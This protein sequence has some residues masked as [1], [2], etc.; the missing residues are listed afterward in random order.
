MI[1][2]WKKILKDYTKRDT[3]LKSSALD[4]FKYIGPGLLVTVGF[5]DPGNWASNFAAGS[6]FGYTLLWV[7]SL[8]TIMLILLQHNVAHLGIV[9]GLCLSEAANKYLPRTGSR[10]VLWSAIAASVSTSLAEILGGAIALNMLFGIPIKVAAVLV[11][12]F[13]FC[14]MFSSSYKKIEKYIIAFVSIIGLSFIYEL[15]LVDIEWGEAARSW[16]VPSVPQGSILIIMS[17][18]GAVVMPHNLFLH[19]EIIQS[20]EWN[21]KDD[22]VIEKQLKYEFFDTLFSMVIGWAINSA[23]ILLAAA[24]FHKQGIVVDDLQQAKSLLEPLLG[25]AAAI[26]FGI[27]LLFAGISSSM[28]SGIAAGSIFAGMYDEPYNIKDI[29]SRT[30]VVISLG[31]ALLIIFLITNP[32]KGLLIS[33][34]VLSMQLPITVFL[35]VRLTSSKEVMGKYANRPTTK[36]TL[37]IIASV[38]TLLNIWLLYTLATGWITE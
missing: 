20:R 30:G 35:Q 14:M 32:F 6:E 23:M 4:L 34:A 12:I 17:V 22:N 28:T 38:V 18:L 2:F 24:T 27:A 33:Q 15:F 26:I 5:I 10:I 21:L 13:V 19:S 37:Y 36:Y 3:K 25:N 8:S 29:H 16:V 31:V 9:T 1:H 11:T 7:V